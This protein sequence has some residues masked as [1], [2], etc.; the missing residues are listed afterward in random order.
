MKKTIVVLSV[1]PALVVGA[2]APAGAQEGGAQSH[3][4][5]S[6]E[7][8]SSSGSGLRGLLAKLFGGSS[9]STDSGNTTTATTETTTSATGDDLEPALGVD[10]AAESTEPAPADDQLDAGEAV[11]TAD[12]NWVE[13]DREQVFNDFVAYRAEQNLGAISTDPALEA[14]AQEWADHLYE[15]GERGHSQLQSPDLGEV[16]A[17]T[18]NASEVIDLWHNSPGHHDIITKTDATKAGIGI[19]EDKD[20]GKVYVMILQ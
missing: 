4:A 12:D 14:R 17:W 13:T 7:S 1:I 20:Y 10:P 8:G 15:N 18:G 16:I 2:V 9:D 5:A 19:A 3:R 11:Q 6:V